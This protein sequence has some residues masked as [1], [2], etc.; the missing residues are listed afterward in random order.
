[1]TLG[2]LLRRAP[3]SLPKLC[4]HQRRYLSKNTK[5]PRARKRLISTLHPLL[6]R[7]SDYL[8]ISGLVSLKFQFY[9]SGAIYAEGSNGIRYAQLTHRNQNKSRSQK[10]PFPANTQG[11]LYYHLRPDASPL[12][13]SL[14]FRVTGSHYV[15]TFD[16][17]DD[18]R[19]PG[20]LPWQITLAQI[21]CRDNYEP[22]REQLVREG[23]VSEEQMLRC[24]AMFRTKAKINAH[25]TLFRLASPFLVD[26][27]S[28]VCLTVAALPD[29]V[30]E[31]DLQVFTVRAQGG[32]CNPWAGSAL[33][34]FEPGQD[35]E[36]RVLHMRIVKIV[37]PVACTVDVEEYSGRLVRPEEGEL[38]LVRTPGGATIPWS[39][40]IDAKRTPTAEALR[41]L[42]DASRAEPHPDT[43]PLD[44]PPS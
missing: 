35:P 16:I 27:A 29:A 28:R 25:G 21:A 43:L 12:E 31:V 26:F 6:I 40:D 7:P 4:P 37:T 2:A 24:Q 17:G 23:L 33:A 42:W 39:Y 32:Y 9:D 36:R 18:L 8:D 41:I 11:F 38:L 15:W 34:R 22:V 13:G 20:G 44:N 10:L 5:T 14:R 19:A 3:Y 30:H 1:M